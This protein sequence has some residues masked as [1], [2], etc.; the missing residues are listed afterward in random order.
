[1]LPRLPVFA[2]LLAL[3]ALVLPA[4]GQVI[5]SGVL[6]IAAGGATIEGDQPAFQ[7]RLRQPKDGFGG[8]EDF[9]FNRAT[10]EYQFHVEARALPGEN[11]YRLLARWEKSDA[12]YLETSFRRF[13]IFY[14]GSGGRLLPRNLAFSYFPEDLAV[15]RTFSYIEFGTIRRDAL[16][17]LIRYDHNERDGTKNSLRWGDSNLGGADYAPRALIPSQLEVNET[18]DVL[19]VT[20]SNRS[21]TDNWKLSARQERARTHNHHVARRRI[22]EPA[23]RYVAMT[24][25]NDS[26]LF[27]SHGYY[28]RR[29]NERLQITA[30]GLVTHIDANLTGQKIYGNSPNAGYSAAF[31]RLSGDVGYFGLVGESHLRQYVAN[32]SAVYRPTPR[33]QIT[34]A[35]KFEDTSV[36]AIES[37]TDTNL[38][39]A[40]VVENPTAA[41]NRRGWHELSEDL[42]VR[43]LRWPKLSLSWRSLIQQGAGSMAES[44][45]LVV[46]GAAAI[47]HRNDYHRTGQRHTLDATWY[48]RPGLTLGAQFNYRLKLADYRPTRDNTDNR[49]TSSNRYPAYL[50][51]QDIASA[52]AILRVSWRSSTSL[53]LVTRYAV[54]HATTTSTMAG[55]PAID[56]G[57]LSRHS[58]TQTATWTV[59]PRLYL[60]TAVNVTYD[61]LVVPRH[62]FTMHGDNNYTSVSTGGGYALG[63]LT[64]VYADY[65]YL[66]TGNYIDNS[67]ATLPLNADYHQHTAFL[68]WVRRQSAHLVYTLRYGFATNRDYTFGGQNNFNAHMIYAKVQHQF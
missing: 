55:L 44:S 11:D 22:T 2:L 15:D 3:L 23:D 40:T 56:N 50:I 54:Q 27:T 65:Q 19:T 67:S 35:A 39:T 53:G 25:G 60:N 6:A 9:S 68:T 62:F 28:E 34:P 7:L 52:D 66:G 26:D 57:R 47:D 61:Q 41:N 38:S 49:A 46:N 64:D 10:P 16:Q 17:F 36:D 59:S 33:W 5:T 31:P 58:I 42:E 21:E 12:V 45:I 37:H 4:G 32:V 13:R 63:K 1:M 20:A 30:G 48:P 18:R 29:V 51:D 14:D 24:D 43:Y 8:V